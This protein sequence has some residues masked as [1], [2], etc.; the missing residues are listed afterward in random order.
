MIDV[1][2]GNEDGRLHRML[3]ASP[4][5][6]WEPMGAGTVI[7]TADGD[8]VRTVVRSEGSVLPRCAQCPLPDPAGY[9]IRRVEVHLRVNLGLD[10][11]ALAAQDQ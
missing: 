11:D 6:P 9:L 1:F 8:P 4:R 10:L 5:K 2:R 7:D 3:Q